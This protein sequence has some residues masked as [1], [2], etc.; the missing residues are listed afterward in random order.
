MKKAFTFFLVLFAVFSKK[1]AKGQTV[2]TT[3]NSRMNHIFGNLDKSKVPYGLLR[4]YA[5]ELTNLENFDGSALTDSNRVDAGAFKAIYNTLAFARVTN[6]AYTTLPSPRA[7]D[8]LWYHARHY[9]QVTLAGLFYRYGYLDSNAVNNGT[10]TVTGDQLFDKY[11]SGVY[12]NPYLQGN[13]AGFAPA[14]TVYHRAPVSMY[15][16]LTVSG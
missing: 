12:Q 7:I 11:V 8:S 3:F 1:N 10:I 16:C 4:D 14:T 9:G 6:A 13:V 2:D 5:L 15:Y